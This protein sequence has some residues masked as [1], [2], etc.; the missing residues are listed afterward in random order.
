M[1]LFPNPYLHIDNKSRLAGSCPVGEPMREGTMPKREFTSASRESKVVAPPTETT[2]SKTDTFFVWS[3]QPIEVSPDMVAPYWHQR[4]TGN[5]VFEVVGEGMVRLYN[6]A[7]GAT[8]VA[9]SLLDA[10]GLAR[11]K[12]FDD[13][14]AAYMKDPDTSSWSK[15]FEIDD[16]VAQRMKDLA[17]ARAAKAKS[18][19]KSAA[20]AAPKKF[21]LEPSVKGEAS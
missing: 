5:E 18:T 14:Q 1:K 10:L 7:T 21:P 4:L 13:Y 15:Q 17:S 20:E 9:A 12:A 11:L 3:C 2:Q 16:E 19:T 8:P 6:R